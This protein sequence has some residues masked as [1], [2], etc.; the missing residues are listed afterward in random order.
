MFIVKAT[1]KCT[2]KTVFARRGDKMFPYM[3]ARG[4]SDYND[5]TGRNYQEAS[6]YSEI[7]AINII[8]DLNDKLNRN[9]GLWIEN[10]EMIKVC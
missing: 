8:D 9:Y 7:D 5:Y 2:N 3:F 10:W 4:Y 1:E 6:I